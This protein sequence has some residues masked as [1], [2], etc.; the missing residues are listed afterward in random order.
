MNIHKNCQSSTRN[1]AK[2]FAVFAAFSM[3]VIEHF[4]KR[5]D[6]AGADVNALQQLAQY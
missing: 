2:I 4:P 5:R 6:S 3:S 1:G